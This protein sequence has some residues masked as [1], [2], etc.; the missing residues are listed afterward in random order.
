MNKLL[1]AAIAMFVLS[2]VADA[3]RGKKPPKPPPPAVAPT[4][5]PA[6]PPKPKAPPTGK[7]RIVGILD[8]RGPTTAD[9]LTFERNLEDQL[10]TNTYW[11]A[12]RAIMRERLRNSTKWTEGCLVH[13]CLQEVR[14]QTSADVVILAALTGSGTSFGFVVTVVRTDTG[15]VVAQETE[16][17]DV[18]T[19]TETMNTAVLATIKLLNQVPPKLP[20]ETAQAGAA[21]DLAVQ[22]AVQPL[23]KKL[24]VANKKN[25]NTL[26]IVMTVVGIAVAGGGT[27]WYFADDKNK[28]GLATATGGGGLALGGIGVLA[29]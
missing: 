17:C 25:N 3:Q 2:G 7:E 5:P 10:D 28:M 16:R 22:M 13:H 12:P 29:F 21:V 4:P 18:C 23:E 15:K 9:E 6:P 26:G 14:V 8:V 1:P 19:F 11:L 24:D 20:D 27:A